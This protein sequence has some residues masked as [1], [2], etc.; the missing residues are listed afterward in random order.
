MP[1]TD[2]L[3]GSNDFGGVQEAFG[4]VVLVGFETRLEEEEC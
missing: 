3:F 1:L 4:A 2:G